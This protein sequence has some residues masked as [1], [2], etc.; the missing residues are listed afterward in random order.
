MGR[1]LHGWR[2]LA[3]SAWGPPNDPQFYG[4][5]E[6]DAGAL[7]R[8]AEDARSASG[9]H[10]TMTHLAGRAV[11]HG[12]AEV[13]ALRV[14]LARGREHDRES[15]DVFFIVT[16][17]N[18]QE[19]TG[20]K[21]A[22]RRPQVR[23][24]DRPGSQP[25]LRGDRRGRRPGAGPGQG[26]AGPAATPGAPPGPARRCL[27]HLR[28]QSRPEPARYAPAGVRRCHDHFG[29]HVGHRPRLLTAGALLPGA[30]AG[31]GRR[32][33]AAARRGGRASW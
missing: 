12:L 24:R 15:V 29:R 28:P 27:A 3:V 21:V 20:V 19:L 26:A 30:A 23:G 9:E 18:G 4:D 6:L 17:G 31:A 13:P 5:L 10:V 22:R 14:R 32:G 2:K 1:R 25:P 33:R 16:S 7:L 11:A 8:Y